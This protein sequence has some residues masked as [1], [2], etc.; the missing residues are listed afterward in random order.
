MAA[1]ISQVT[2]FGNVVLG[3]TTKSRYA[4]ARVMFP[5]L[6][7]V[8]PRADSRPVP[9]PSDGVV[10]SPTHTYGA[11]ALGRQRFMAAYPRVTHSISSADNQDHQWRRE[12]GERQQQ[13]KREGHRAGRGYVG[14]GDDDIA[15]EPDGIGAQPSLRAALVSGH[16][17]SL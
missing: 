3:D 8:A 9:M 7:S 10:A 12:A 15:A 6:N 17:F 16:V 1:A 5:I 13:R 11:P 2:T 14:Y 4:P